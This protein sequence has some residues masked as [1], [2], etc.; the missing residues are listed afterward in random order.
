M[1]LGIAACPG[2]RAFLAY[3]L[4]AQ[5]ARVCIRSTASSCGAF[6]GSS[7]E[8]ARVLGIAQLAQCLLGF[9]KALGS[10]SNPALAR[11]SGTHL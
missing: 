4:D 7:F 11:Y 6:L 2:H 3:M 10:I 9:H 1:A 8:P 5:G